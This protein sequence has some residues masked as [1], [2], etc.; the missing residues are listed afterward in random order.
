M[1]VGRFRLWL[2]WLWLN[3][4]TAGYSTLLQQAKALGDA[5]QALRQ[6]NHDRFGHACK[7]K[8]P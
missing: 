8:Q 5:A 6:V 1:D 4:L 2:V 3:R 7:W